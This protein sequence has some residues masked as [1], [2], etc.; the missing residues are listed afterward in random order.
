M[1]YTKIWF[2]FVQLNYIIKILFYFYIY[3]LRTVIWFNLLLY[4]NCAKLKWWFFVHK[5]FYLGT[6]LG[7]YW[8]S[9]NRRRGGQSTV[10]SIADAASS[11]KCRLISRRRYRSRTCSGT[12][13]ANFPSLIESKTRWRSYA[14]A[15]V[16][17]EFCMRC[18][19]A[20]RLDL[21]TLEF[22]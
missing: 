14:S 12:R 9:R 21:H 2:F 17:I 7:Q 13:S 15:Y 10:E 11:I 4:F 6:M 18:L 22:I 1:D 16:K 5:F 3:L 20:I 19:D 8:F